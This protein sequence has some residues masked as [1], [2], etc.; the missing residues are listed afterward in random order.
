MSTVVYETHCKTWHPEQ[1]AKALRHVY[2]KPAYHPKK[3]LVMLVTKEF[4]PVPWGDVRGISNIVYDLYLLHWDETTQLLY[5]HSSNTDSLHEGLAKAVCGK[6]ISPLRGE[7]VFRVLY[8]INRLI[9]MNLGLGHSLSRAVRFTMHVGADI[10]EGLTEAHAHNKFKTNIFGRG[11]AG[12]NRATVGCSRKGRIW[13]Y[14]VAGDIGEWV[15]WS[16]EIGKKLQNNQI[17][18]SDVLKGAMVPSPVIDRPV[19]VPLAVEWSDDLLDRS[20][21]NVHLSL[22]GVEVSMSDVSIELVDHAEVG[23]IRFRICCDAWPSK[24]AE[25]RLKFGQNRVDYEPAKPVEPV[26][27]LARRKRP[28]SEYLQEEPPVIRFHDGSFLIYDNLFTP[29]TARPAL[30][31][32][33]RI[34]AWD[35]TGVDLKMESQKQ[36]KRPYSIQR[37][38]IEKLL[39]AS[40]AE[41]FD[42]VFDDDE[43]GESADI[44]AIRIEQAHLL[45][46]LYHCKFSGAAQPGARIDDLYAVCGQAQSSVHWRGRPEQ[47]LEHMI[48]REAKRISKNGVSR[49]ERGDLKLLTQLKRRLRTLRPEFQIY[50]VQPGLSGAAARADHLELLSAT[51][52]HLRETYS[53][54]LVVI[55]SA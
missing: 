44:V 4:E 47:L 41:R 53:V 3:R 36:A 1:A 16:H 32:R 35:W 8:D 43:S 26:I 17:D 28:L 13:S 39:A 31:D 23:P 10:K 22:A 29:P 18:V 48:N 6:E 50:I 55:A 12:G 46:R 2:D 24:F 27:L 38:A 30:Y 33:A 14:R 7:R 15:D 40:G 45:F 5:I 42:V 25:Y 49:F 54:P 51:E 11:F 52:L 21:E 34:E 19:K 20:E 37:R 9:L